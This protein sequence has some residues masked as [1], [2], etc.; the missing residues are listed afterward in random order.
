[1]TKAEA[2]TLMESIHGHW[3]TLS[4]KKSN[5]WNREVSATWSQYLQE[6]DYTVTCEVV[7]DFF[8]G[9]EPMPRNTQKPAF[10]D[11]RYEV[12]RRLATRDRS[13]GFEAA[14]PGPVRLK[15]YKDGDYVVLNPPHFPPFKNCLPG[16]RVDKTGVNDCISDIPYPVNWIDCKGYHLMSCIITDPAELKYIHLMNDSQ[17]EAWIRQMERLEADKQF[18]KFRKPRKHDRGGDPKALSD[19]F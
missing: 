8:L 11:I 15:A 1:M 18:S 19:L 2:F 14:C 3:P 5:E 17:R 16:G 6:L 9:D 12:R 13:D 7:R 4:L 10:K